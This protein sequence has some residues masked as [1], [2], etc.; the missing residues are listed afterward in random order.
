MGGLQEMSMFD[1]RMGHAYY[2]FASGTPFKAREFG[3]RRDAEAAMQRWC[4]KEGIQLECTEC[5]KHERK[6]S[7]HKGVRFYINRV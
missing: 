7:N 3:T 5:D 2:A 1:S 4:A 6:Y